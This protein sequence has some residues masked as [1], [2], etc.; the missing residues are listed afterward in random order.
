MPKIVEELN[1]LNITV[2][3]ANTIKDSIKNT[4]GWDEI[5][6]TIPKLNDCINNIPDFT[7]Y[8]AIPFIHSVILDAICEA[9][10]RHQGELN[11]LDV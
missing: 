4:A 11:H 2:E 8:S 3:Q 6:K 10:N 7:G 9:T 5:V 1:A